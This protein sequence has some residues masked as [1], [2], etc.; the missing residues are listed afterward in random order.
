M[1]KQ[2]REE[3]KEHLRSHND[4]RINIRAELEIRLLHEK[5]DHLLLKQRERLTEIQ[6]IQFDTMEEIAQRRSRKL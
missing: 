6:Q 4:Y 1:M 3:A 2:R 5:L